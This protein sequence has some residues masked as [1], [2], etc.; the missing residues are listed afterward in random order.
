MFLGSNSVGSGNHSRCHLFF[1]DLAHHQCGTVGLLYLISNTEA[2]S[3]GISTTGEPTTA[4]RGSNRKKRR[5]NGESVILN[6]NAHRTENERKK[7]RSL[8]TKHPYCAIVLLD[9]CQLHYWS[10]T[11]RVVRSP[12]ISIGSEP[13]I[14]FVCDKDITNIPLYSYMKYVYMRFGETFPNVGQFIS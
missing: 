4:T 13:S 3:P 10:R 8:S 7:E 2:P 6:D 12:A 14:L 11:R 9:Y 5:G 1:D